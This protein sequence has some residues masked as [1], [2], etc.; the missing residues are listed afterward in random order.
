MV[1][2]ASISFSMNQIRKGN[3]LEKLAPHLNDLGSAAPM[4][5]RMPMCWRRPVPGQSD[6][7]MLTGM[8]HGIGSCTF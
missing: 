5:P 1:R 4:S 2:S 8:M 6:E 3:K 7:A